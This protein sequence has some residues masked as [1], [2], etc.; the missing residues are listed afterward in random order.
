MSKQEPKKRSKTK[1]NQINI[2]LKRI[3]H[4]SPALLDLAALEGDVDAG[5]ARRV[6]DGERLRLGALLR[7]R[8]YEGELVV[9][10]GVHLQVGSMIDFFLPS[11]PQ[12]LVANY[13][14]NY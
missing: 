13:G 9:D 1:S 8:N 10:D 12:Y 7:G 2:E 6:R 3:D 5:V 11:C 4:L 14:R